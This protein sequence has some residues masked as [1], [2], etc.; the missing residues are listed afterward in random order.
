M[1][2]MCGFLRLWLLFFFLSSLPLF[3][4]RHGSVTVRGAGGGEVVV[5]VGVGVGGDIE[6]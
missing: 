2:E 5:V 6:Q 3:F 4:S 1:C